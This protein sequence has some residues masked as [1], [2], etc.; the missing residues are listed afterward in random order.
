MPLQALLSGPGPYQHA[1]AGESAPRPVT[2]RRGLSTF[3]TLGGLDTRLVGALAKQG[4][5]EATVI[6]EKGALRLLGAVTE[7]N[8]VVSFKGRVIPKAMVLAAPTGSGKTLAYT[9][10]ALQRALDSNVPTL[11][12]VPTIELMEQVYSMTQPLASAVGLDVERLYP[13]MLYRPRALPSLLL[14]TPALL[15]LPQNRSWIERRITAFQYLVLDEADMLLTGAGMNKDAALWMQIL[16]TAGADAPIGVFAGATMPNQ[17]PK[18]AGGLLTRSF[19]S[20]VE[21][22]RT[23]DFQHTNPNVS[24]AFLPL[25]SADVKALHRAVREHVSATQEAGTVLVF[26]DTTDHADAMLGYLEGQLPDHLVVGFSR[27]V[28]REQRLALLRALRKPSPRHR[29]VVCTDA[30]ARGID[31]CDVVHVIQ[32]PLASNA[33]VHIH[34][35]GRTGRHSSTGR[36]TN[37][38]LPVQTHLARAL[39]SA[40]DSNT[41]LTSS[42]S[43]NRSFRHRH[44]HRH[45]DPQ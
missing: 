22:I 42:L 8:A 4:I 23:D 32:A 17:S 45:R 24:Q 1:S 36:V 26:T 29:V 11:C 33:T 7:P 25:A 9:I 44:R 34:R 18:T 19:K 37:L 14:S 20:N 6:Q 40:H 3:A 13:N 10:P 27:S 15:R 30:A 41:S 28:P 35:V 31:F 5:T 38:W 43:R 39:A 12:L 2:M 16:R 21:W